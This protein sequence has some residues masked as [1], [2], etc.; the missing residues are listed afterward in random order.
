MRKLMTGLLAAATLGVTPALGQ[1]HTETIV[2]EQRLS[3]SVSVSPEAA[4]AFLPQ[5]WTPVGSNLSVIF[6]D[7][8]LQFTPDGGPLGVGANE[9]LVLVMTARNAQGAV[10]AMVVGGYSADPA[11]APGAYG[12]Y[13]TGDVGVTR[14]EH[15]TVAADHVETRVDEH[16]TVQGDDGVKLDLEIAYTR[17]IPTLRPLDIQVYSGAHPDFH[18]NYRGQQADETLL[19]DSGVNRVQSVTLTASGGRLG[20]AIGPAAQITSITVTPYYTRQT[21]VP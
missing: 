12:V 16:W 2:Q 13:Q 14:T 18:R 21:F 7:R 5:G 11:Q 8:S 19:N 3:L 15:K 10:H 17:G 9:M 20:Q 1:T 4:A 6:M